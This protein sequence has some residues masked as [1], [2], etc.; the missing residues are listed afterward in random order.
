M[1]GRPPRSTPLRS[2]KF[3]RPLTLRVVTLAVGPA[4]AWGD[5]ASRAEFVVLVNSLAEALGPKV[6]TA[7]AKPPAAE[8]PPAPAKAEEPPPRGLT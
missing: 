1:A 8:P 3:T 7:A 6:H 4:P 2:T 5:L